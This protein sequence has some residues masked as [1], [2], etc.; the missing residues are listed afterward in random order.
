MLRDSLRQAGYQNGVCTVVGRARRSS[1]PFFMERLPVNSC[2][3]T[4]LFQAKLAGA[5]DWISKS[6]YVV[7]MVKAGLLGS[8]SGAKQPISKDFPAVQ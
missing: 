1:D 4:A 3:D 6:Q 5:Y 7:K 8:V 2:D